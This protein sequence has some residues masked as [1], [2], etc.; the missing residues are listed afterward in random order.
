MAGKDSERTRQDALDR[1]VRWL[2]VLAIG[3]LVVAVPAFLISIALVYFTFIQAEAT[4]RMQEAETWPFVS[5]ATS[6]YDAEGN[7]RI[8]LG[9]TNNGVGP[10]QVRSVELRYRG[11][12]VSSFREL[13]EKCC[14]G[15]ERNLGYGESSLAGE[16]L[17]PGQT[18]DFAFL[19]PQMAG[20]EVWQRFEQERFGVEVDVCYCSVFDECRVFSTTQNSA[21]AVDACPVPP[22]PFGLARRADADARET[23]P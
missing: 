9:L 5:Y 8:A 17:R 23:T 7:P 18:I 3:N 20:E 11:E 1:V 13:L 16:V 19:I 14:A 21:K 2:P 6:N 15:D 22:T 4:D 12:A 10:A